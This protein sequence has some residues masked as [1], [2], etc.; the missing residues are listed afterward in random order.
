MKY[1]YALFLLLIGCGLRPD[2]DIYTAFPKGTLLNRETLDRASQVIPYNKFVIIVVNN[3]KDP[4]K[5]DPHLLFYDSNFRLISAC[6]LPSQR[7]DFIRGILSF[8]F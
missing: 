2:N 1:L 6:Y 8:V 7:I 3:S 5:Y 4:L